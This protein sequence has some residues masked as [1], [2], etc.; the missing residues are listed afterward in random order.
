MLDLLEKPETTT[1]KLPL[2]RYANG[3]GY[4][5]QHQALKP[6][7]YSLDVAMHSDG[8]IVGVGNRTFGRPCNTRG[9]MLVLVEDRSC[10]SPEV[11]SICACPDTACLERCH[12]FVTTCL[13][14]LEK[15]PLNPK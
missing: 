4:K 10:L 5:V 8:R 14:L 11:D 1:V 15:E 9:R 13:G 7:L 3:M 6:G 12:S 2:E